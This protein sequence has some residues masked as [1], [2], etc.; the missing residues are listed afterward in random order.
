MC[1]VAT[2]HMCLSPPFKIAVRY[3]IPLLQILRVD[4]AQAFHGLQGLQYLDLA[5][6]LSLCYLLASSVDVFQMHQAPSICQPQVFCIYHHIILECSLS[7]THRHK[8][9]SLRLG[10]LT[11][12]SLP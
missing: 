2:S 4:Q 1:A 11:Q 9:L 3:T 12:Y 8:F 5:T 6:S 7:D 10:L